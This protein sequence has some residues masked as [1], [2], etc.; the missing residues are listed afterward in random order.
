MP[1]ALQF[2][3]YAVCAVVLTG[4]LLFLGGYTGAM[5]GRHKS[6]GNPEDG[7][8]PE[9]DHDAVVRVT[10]AHRNAL[11]NIPIFLGL[12]LAYAIV[13]ASPVGAKVT[14]VGFTGARVLH[15]FF[16]LRALQPWRTIAFALGSLFL[17][18]MAVLLLVA[19]F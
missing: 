2:Q 1:N 6:A 5:R 15:T 14:F 17:V 19:I 8:V 3:L 13:G 4:L 10:R 18:G 7:K 16:H 12:G 9:H 11:E